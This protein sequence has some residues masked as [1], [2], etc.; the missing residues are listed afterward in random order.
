MLR[1]LPTTA[2]F[3][4]L[5]ALAALLAIPLGASAQGQGPRNDRFPHNLKVTAAPR[6]A[7]NNMLHVV[8]DGLD[9][10]RGLAFAPNG[11]LFV[12]E[13][14]EGGDNCFTPDPG[15]PTF[16]VCTGDTGAISEINLK[17]GTQTR[18]ATGFPSRAAPDGFEAIGPSDISFQGQGNGFVAIGLGADPAFRDLLGNGFG[19]LARTTPSGQWSNRV[20]V[21]QYEV[22]YNPD[23]GLVD[24]NPY[25]VQALSGNTALVADAGANALLHTNIATGAIQTVAVFPERVVPVDPMLQA[26]FGL[27]PFMPAE[28][29][30]NAV[31]L[32]PDGAYYVAELLG[33]P[34]TPG[35]SRVYRIVPGQQPEVFA[36]GFTSIID[37]GFDQQ[38]NLY[39]LEV[40]K[41]GLVA[42][43]IFGDWTGALIKVEAGTGVQSEI[44]SAGLWA[45]GGLAVAADGTFYVSNNSIWADIGQVLH[46]V[47]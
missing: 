36:A 10:P 5:L 20:D 2:R 3:A 47:P 13:A 8:A 37:I 14:G 21:A 24:S 6:A 39:V 1:R 45:P 42:G 44:A 7:A 28:S 35:E 34:F 18:V 22:D 23:G 26:I 43:F 4:V 33:F 27:P 46:I 25:S 40:A 41:N 19:W 11:L 31:T 17:K 12:A 29:V 16:V 32:G 15:D 9:N 30:P 38:G